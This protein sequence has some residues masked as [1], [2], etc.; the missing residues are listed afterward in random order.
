MLSFE[1]ELGPEA[2]RSAICTA[3]HKMRVSPD[4]KPPELNAWASGSEL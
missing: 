1:G 4:E 3:D 2:K